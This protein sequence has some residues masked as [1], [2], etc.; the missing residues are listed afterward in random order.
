MKWY[1]AKLKWTQFFL[2]HKLF[3]FD[4][5]V[6]FTV[7]TKSGTNCGHF[8]LLV[9]YKIKPRDILCFKDTAFSRNP[10]QQPFWTN[11]EWKY[12]QALGLVDI[13]CRKCWEFT[14]LC[15]ILQDCFNNWEKWKKFHCESVALTIKKAYNP[16]M[17]FLMNKISS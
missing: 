7:L 3:S 16:L 17:L 13:F 4:H 9:M 14:D 10:Y 2:L 8:A 5:Q 15:S 12:I 1:D 6:M 11:F